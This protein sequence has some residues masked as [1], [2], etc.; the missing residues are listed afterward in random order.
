MPLLPNLDIPLGLEQAY[1]RVISI[2]TGLGGVRGFS[3][4]QSPARAYW[5]SYRLRSLFVQLA[6][7]YDLLSVYRRNHWQWYWNWLPFTPNL[8]LRGWPGSGFSAFVYY[9]APRLRAGLPLQLDAP[10]SLYTFG[11]PPFSTSGGGTFGYSGNA[12]ISQQYNA[13]ST[14]TLNSFAI[15][16]YRVNGNPT[17]NLVLKIYKNGTN[18]EN[19]TLVAGPINYPMTSLNNSFLPGGPIFFDLPSPITINSGNTYYFTIT[20]SGAL[21]LTNSPAVEYGSYA[22]MGFSYPPA[23]NWS[24]TFTGWTALSGNQFY[25]LLF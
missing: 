16:I 3:K 22:D 1:R 19:G 5:P 6:P 8:G 7:G 15:A 4:R 12:R 2:A 20:R 18:P 24:Y 23:R 13:T 21:S 11:S 25:F 14:F 10:G 9:N 17:D